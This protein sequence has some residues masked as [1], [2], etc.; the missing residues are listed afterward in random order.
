MLQ[1]IDLTTIKM[2]ETTQVAAT[3]IG[4]GGGVMKT[5]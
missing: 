1:H 4:G 5:V 2:C 3:T